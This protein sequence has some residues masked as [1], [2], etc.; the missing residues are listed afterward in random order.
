MWTKSRRHSQVLQPS[1]VIELLTVRV[2]EAVAIS[3]D[4]VVV[5][6]HSRGDCDLSLSHNADDDDDDDGDGDDD[7]R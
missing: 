3:A 4:N 6:V 1:E 5:L 7:E 2:A